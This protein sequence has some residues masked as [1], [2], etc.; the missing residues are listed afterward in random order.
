MRYAAQWSGH[1]YGNLRFWDNDPGAFVALFRVVDHDRPNAWGQSQPVSGETT[2][3]AAKAHAKAL[4][5]GLK[6]GI[7]QPT[8][9]RSRSGGRRAEGLVSEPGTLKPLC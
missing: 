6:D 7:Q 3:E 5:D 4:N 9:T 8:S 1:N 2:E